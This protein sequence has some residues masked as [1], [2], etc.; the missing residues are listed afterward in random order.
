MDKRKKIGPGEIKNST[1]KINT[2]KIWREETHCQLKKITTKPH[3]KKRNDIAKKDKKK[4]ML[5]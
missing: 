1:R 2:S 4:S 3:T 5:K